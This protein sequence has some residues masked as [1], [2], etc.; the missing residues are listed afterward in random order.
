MN[1]LEPR[2][3]VAHILKFTGLLLVAGIGLN[4]CSSGSNSINVNNPGNTNTSSTNQLA[5]TITD[6][7]GSPIIGAT[8]SGDSNTTTSTQEGDFVLSNVTVPAGQNSLVFTVSASATVNGQNWTGQNTVE[9]LNGFGPASDAMVVLSNRSTQATISGQLTDQN[10]TPLA[11]ARVFVAPGPVSSNGS[12]YFLNLA[13][14]TTYTDQN[15]NYTIP[16]L[17]TTLKDGSNN[18]VSYTVTG[19]FAGHINQ[20]VSNIAPNP[21]QNVQVNL[22]LDSSSNGSTISPVQG[23]VVSTFTIPSSPNR[24]AGISTSGSTSP[25]PMIINSVLHKLGMKASQASPTKA[26]QVQYAKNSPTRSTP[27]GSIVETDLFWNYIPQ[28][29]VLGF[30]ILRSD[31]N[32][33]NFFSEALLR[34]PLGDRYADV[35]PALTP[36]SIYFY[37]VAPVDTILFPQN[38][39]EGQAVSSATFQV[40]PLSPIN[41]QDGYGN[42]SMSSLPTLQWTPLSNVGQYTVNI[43]SQYPSYQS[44]SNGINPIVSDVVNGSASQYT[45]S[46]PTDTPL[47]PGTYYWDVIAQ[48]TPPTSAPTV[49]YSYAISQIGS[50]VVP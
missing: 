16:D 2:K 3:P 17:P 47:A 36:G 4:G 44:N 6:I 13:S 43:Y 39:T 37:N 9:V 38:G 7:N 22:T 28:N 50:F 24:A 14:F 40:S 46:Q 41:I 5:G 29:N 33:A 1:S 18:A 15:G 49:G 26:V 12:Q 45:L 8:V 31:G 19:S 20:T 23:L 30:D 34:D 48:Y 35:D 21:G 11:G 10:G 42:Q 27:A 32:N 25:Y